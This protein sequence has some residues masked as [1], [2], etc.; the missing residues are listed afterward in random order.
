MDKETFSK[1]DIEIQ[2]EY[3]N[4][5]M[6]VGKSF[7][8]VCK[9]IGYSDESTLRKKYN[10]KEYKLNDTKTA[11][12]KVCDRGMTEVSKTNNTVPKKVIEKNNPINDKGMN[13]VIEHTEPIQVVDDNKVT[14]VTN[15]DD[16]SM[17]FNNQIKSNLIGLAENYDRIMELLNSDKNMTSG[18]NIELPIETVDNFR[19]TVRVNN[20]V[21]D[22]FKNF[23]KEHKEFTQRDL[24][25]EALL[26]YINNHK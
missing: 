9:E 2:I 10:K 22:N 20:V 14:Q 5:E 17:T 16:N 18:I 25:S 12:I 26:E 3:I 8:Q 21:W 15:F 11:Y 13:V 6:A 7:S 1:F 19:T 24:L 23:C 4:S